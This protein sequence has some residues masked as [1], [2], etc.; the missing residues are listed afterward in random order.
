MSLE[1]ILLGMLAEPAS[2]YDL[3]AEFEAGARHFWFAELSQIY[4][5]LRRMERRTWLTSQEEPSP[6]GPARRVYTRT[7]LGTAELLKWLRSG[8][9]VGV[10]RFAYIGQLIFLGQLNDL[11]TTLAF[12]ERLRDL[13]REKLQFL[14]AA[15]KETSAKFAGDPDERDG[16]EFHEHLSLRMGIVSLGAKVRSCN[17]CIKRVKDRMAAETS[18][19]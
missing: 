8:P 12:L 1:H 16:V 2:G 10:E 5:T 11:E 13:H 18:H 17:E 6:S 9:V 14:K 7:R 19:V 15:E 4:P 3:K